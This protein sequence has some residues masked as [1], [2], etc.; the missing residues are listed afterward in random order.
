[1]KNLFKIPFFL[2]LIL[3]FLSFI[4][5]SNFLTYDYRTKDE[6]QV[7]NLTLKN[8]SEESLLYEYMIDKNY[9]GLGPLHFHSFSINEIGGWQ[10][11]IDELTTDSDI[12]FEYLESFDSRIIEG[13][14]HKFRQYYRGV[15]VVDGG[16]TV[17]S[18]KTSSQAAVAPP[19]VGCPPINLC[20]EIQMINP[21][22]YENIDISILPQL[23]LNQII[24]R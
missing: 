11:F 20:A 17:V 18:E 13:T 22:I 12:T 4:N 10:Y 3:T 6:C 15:E 9:D 2:L 16:F 5:K 21:S 14:Y 23:S 24:E 8:L 19:C 7:R 1:M